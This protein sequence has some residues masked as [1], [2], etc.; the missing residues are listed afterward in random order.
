MMH[1]TISLDIN[2]ANTVILIFGMLHAAVASTLENVI[3]DAQYGKDNNAK[4]LKRYKDIK[5]LQKHVNEL[6][7]VFILTLCYK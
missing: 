7:T 2:P 5:D 6:F 4:W 3:Y 1:S